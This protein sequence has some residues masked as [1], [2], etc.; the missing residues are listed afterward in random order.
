MISSS[1]HEDEPLGTAGAIRHAALVLSAAPSER[2]VMLNGD[3]L[4]GHD[5]RAQLARHDQTGADVT[6]H[7]VEVPDARPY[8]CVPTDDEDRVLAFEE[9]SPHPVSHQINAGCYIFTREV[10]D[11]IPADRVVSVER[12]T[13]P[14]LLAAGA[15]VRGFLDDSYWIDVGTPAALCRVSADIVGGVASSPAYTSAPG[16]AWVH[17]TAVVASSAVVT[18]GSA[19]G[20][21]ATIGANA[22]VDGTVVGDGAVI[23]SGARLVRCIVDVGAV[24][25][26]GAVCVDGVMQ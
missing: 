10:I 7:L 3:I 19:V 4:S 12:E 1:S 16:P 13:F 14:G 25:E 21:G 20:P 8:G 22:V 26:P 5:L 24:V 2:V 18:G 11:A 17:P 15:N 9:K 6:L 23:G